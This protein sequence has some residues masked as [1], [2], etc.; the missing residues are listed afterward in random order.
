MR[1][2][3]WICLLTGFALISACGQPLD[4]DE[5]P[6]VMVDPAM[7]QGEV[8]SVPIS[9][10]L[11]RT[12]SMV[13]LDALTYRGGSWLAARELVF[14][15]VLVRH[16][17]GNFLFDSGLGKNIDAQYE[18]M[19][20]YLRPLTAYAREDAVLEQL[21]ANGMAPATIDRILLS[22]LHWDHVSGVEDF[23]GA[24][25]MLPKAEHEAATDGQGPLGYLRSQLKNENINWQYL[26]FV[27]QPYLNFERSHDLFGDG[28]VILVPMQ[29]H[30]PG[31]M[32]MFLNFPDGRRYFFSGDTTWTIEGFREPAEKFLFARKLI[33]ENGGKTRREIARVHS[34]M[35][36]LPDLVVVP[37]H[38]ANVQGSIGYFPKF[39]E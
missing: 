21:Q 11:I 34:L 27:D 14:S 2:L 13:S 15:S 29:G 17:E 18:D 38:D 19:P 23:P 37:A 10:S 33:G 12:G 7:L 25:V 39:I 20:E 5:Y 36:A 26:E 6:E 24:S 31:S 4:P 1:Y 30:T 28:S 3:Q 35:Q 9:F 8:G 22:H 32:G 16:P